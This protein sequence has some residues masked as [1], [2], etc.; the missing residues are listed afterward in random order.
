LQKDRDKCRQTDINADKKREKDK[1]THTERQTDRQ[2]DIEVLVS[3]NC[4]TVGTNKSK[5][6]TF[7]HLLLL[8]LSFFEFTYTKL[9]ALNSFDKHCNFPKVKGPIKH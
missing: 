4:N 8:A 1:Q 9:F 5:F 3:E 7:F 6:G 2:A